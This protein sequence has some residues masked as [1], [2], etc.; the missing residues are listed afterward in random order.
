MKTSLF[1]L[2]IISMIIGGCAEQKKSSIEGTWQVV[3]WRN[4]AG[5]SLVWELGDHFSGTEM[6]IWSVDHFA[7][8]GRYKQDTTFIDN[9]GGGTYKLDGIQCVES[10]Q[11]FVDQK[12]VGTTQKLLIEIKNDTMTQ[13]WPVDDNWQIVKSKYNIQK[14]IRIK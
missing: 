2:V 13:T 8:V 1:L 4:M 14:L 5:D 11:Y 3:S 12:M 7:F 10:Y 9:Y 6:K